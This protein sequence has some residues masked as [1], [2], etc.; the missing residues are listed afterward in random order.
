MSEGLSKANHNKDTEKI[1]FAISY[2]HGV[3]LDY[4]EPF[5]GE[6]LSTQPYNFLEE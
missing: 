5:I 6:E 4:F 3:A 2:L 1:F